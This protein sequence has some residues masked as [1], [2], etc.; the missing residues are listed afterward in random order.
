VFVTLT[1]DI[2]DSLVMA[3]YCG[4]LSVDTLFDASLA[5]P[6]GKSALHRASMRNDVPLPGSSRAIFTR[7]SSTLLEFHRSI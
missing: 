1:P 3:Q 6:P 5:E 4:I 2:A 7:S